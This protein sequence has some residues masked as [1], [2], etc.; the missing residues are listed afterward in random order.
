MGF[1]G[2]K[3]ETWGWLEDIDLNAGAAALAAIPVTDQ[4]HITLSGTDTII[5]PEHVT[6]LHG[7]LTADETRP[8]TDA[9]LLTISG[10]TSPFRLPTLGLDDAFG[11]HRFWNPIRIPE[12]ASLSVTGNGS[13][14]GAEEHAVILLIENPLANPWPIKAI[15]S[16]AFPHYVE[17]VTD[18]PPAAYRTT[19]VEYS[20]RTNAYE[21]S[22][23]V[24]PDL[25]DITV[26]LRG[27]KPELTAGYTCTVIGDNRL[28][29]LLI[30]PAAST[31]DPYWNLADFIGGPLVST[32]KSCHNVGISGVSNGTQQLYLD[33][34]IE[35]WKGNYTTG[36]KA[37]GMSAAARAL[38]GNTSV[39][40]GGLSGISN[41]ASGVYTALGRKVG[42]LQ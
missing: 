16:N 10:Y 8:T 36:T 41:Q 42:R 1:P 21:N 37:G 22:Q 7:I 38:T 9:G 24:L 32:A 20:G 31:C 14:A 39:T 12:G 35:G 15:P 29:K 4:K 25:D 11:F 3:I 6:Y 17:M 28:E 27:V 13:G 18:A 30:L 34:Y 40:T 26:Y 2:P 23:E 33:L 19:Q 5:A